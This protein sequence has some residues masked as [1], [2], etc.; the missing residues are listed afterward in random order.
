MP[1]IRPCTPCCCCGGGDGSAAAAAGDLSR[2]GGPQRPCLSAATSNGTT[3]CR[4]LWTSTACKQR[5]SAANTY[6]CLKAC[7][8]QTMYVGSP[9]DYPKWLL[10]PYWTVQ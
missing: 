9:K 1:I 7:I 8:T 2:I 5:G 4:L 10:P 3:T 6:R